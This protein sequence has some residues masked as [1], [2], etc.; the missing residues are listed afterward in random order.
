M[1]MKPAIVVVAYNRDKALKRLLNSLESA[2]YSGFS[3]ITLVISIDKSDSTEVIETAEAFSWEQ[4]EKR[5]ITHPERLGLKKHILG[6]GDL[7]AEFGSIIMLEDD[8]FVS[9]LLYHYG[10][11]G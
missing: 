4:G 6:L 1:S 2:D 5:V 7:T 11:A 10:C 9:P 8:L 3:D